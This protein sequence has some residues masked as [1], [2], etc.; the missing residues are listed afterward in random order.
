LV[1]SFID[2]VGLSGHMTAASAAGLKIIT[3]G[4]IQIGLLVA[5][6]ESR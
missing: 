6:L 2:D 4:I 5:C 1:N 3:Q